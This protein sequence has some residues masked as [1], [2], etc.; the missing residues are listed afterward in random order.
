M[1]RAFKAL[2]FQPKHTI[3]FVLF[4]NEE[5]GTRGAKKYAEEA[6]SKNEK[7]IFALESDAGGFTPRGFGF[8]V[9][10]EVWPKLESW[11]KS[12]APYGGDLFTH[13]CEDA[14]ISYLNEAFKTPMAGLQPDSQRYFD[15]HHAVTDVFEAVNIRELKLGAVNMAALLY[16]VDKYGL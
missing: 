10:P 15:Y 16:L 4:A 8:E 12:F 2:G 6:K 14:D 1:L 13:G 11:K 7:H 5:N 3:R 9:K